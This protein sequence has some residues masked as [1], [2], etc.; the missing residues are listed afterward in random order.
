MTVELKPETERLVLE[1]L[2]SGHVRTVDELIVHGV[3]ALREKS[4]GAQ[5]AA[6]P[7]RKPRQNLA[8]V[9]RQYGIIK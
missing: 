3:Q 5:A 1:E 6:V 7:S 9:L 8:D 2:R 4:K